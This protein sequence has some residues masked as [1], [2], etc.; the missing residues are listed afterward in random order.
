M[1]K[2]IQ[3]YSPNEKCYITC[4]H[5]QFCAF[6]KHLASFATTLTAQDTSKLIE[7]ERNT[8]R[9]TTQI[10]G[11]DVNGLRYIGINGLLVMSLRNGRGGFFITLIWPQRAMLTSRDNIHIIRQ[12]YIS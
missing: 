12:K 7:N 5:Y 11:K 10:S 2:R 4:T 1:S 3:N 9:S 6:R 8:G